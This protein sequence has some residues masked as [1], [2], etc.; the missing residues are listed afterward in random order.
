[1]PDSWQWRAKANSYLDPEMKS[2]ASKPY[3]EQFIK[4][5][6]AG[7]DQARYKNFLIE[8]YQYLGAFY[9]NK[10]DK[11]TAGPFLNKAKELDPNNELTKE[12]LKNL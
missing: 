6:E 12:L 7:T 9:I 3:Y 11:A 8:S 10:G 4:V 5:A 2:A 1:M